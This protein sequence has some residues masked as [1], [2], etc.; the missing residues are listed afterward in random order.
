MQWCALCE[1]CRAVVA[2]RGCNKLVPNTAMLSRFM[3]KVIAVKPNPVQK[4]G[5]WDIQQVS[6]FHG[7]VKLNCSK[8]RY[9]KTNT[10][11]DTLTVV[12]KDMEQAIE[13]ALYQ[14]RLSDPYQ[15]E[16]KYKYGDWNIDCF[17]WFNDNEMVTTIIAEKKNETGGLIGIPIWITDKDR[18]IARERTK[19]IIDHIE[20]AESEK[21][22]IENKYIYLSFRENTFNN[23]LSTLLPPTR[24]PVLTNRNHQTEFTR[25]SRTNLG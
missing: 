14:I 10:E 12:G 7:G 5:D 11:C 13:F 6:Q 20:N 23:P 17:R 25:R 16:P 1:Q 2:E 24:T 21:M 9:Q 19:E 18:A 4:C 22:G 15:L 3:N 8:T